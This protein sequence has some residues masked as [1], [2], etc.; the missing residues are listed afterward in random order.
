MLMIFDDGTVIRVNE[1]QTDWTLRIKKGADGLWKDLS[2]T[3]NDDNSK[4]F[5]TLWVGQEFGSQLTPFGNPDWRF[6]PFAPK[7]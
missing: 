5:E 6:N 4:N 7:K 3:T 1:K 2:L